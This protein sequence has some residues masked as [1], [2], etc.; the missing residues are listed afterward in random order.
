MHTVELLLSKYQDKIIIVD[1]KRNSLDILKDLVDIKEL[2]LN[3]IHPTQLEIIEYNVENYDNYDN[4]PIKLH[5]Y[6]V[7]WNKKS[8][9]YYNKLDQPQNISYKPYFEKPTIFVIHDET[10]GLVETNSELL[11]R[12]Y[13]ML[14]G[15]TQQDLQEKN[16]YLFKY[17]SYID[18][19]T[20]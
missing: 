3:I 1:E 17:L 4:S 13:I 9:F 10:F 11:H 16:Q 12:D 19:W 6:K 15:V 18:A 8:G 2:D 7:I 14:R 5:L 20:E